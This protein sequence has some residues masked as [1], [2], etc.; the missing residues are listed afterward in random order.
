MDGDDA[1]VRRSEI[2]PSLL[3]RRSSLAGA[4]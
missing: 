2:A 4:G 3:V 1:A